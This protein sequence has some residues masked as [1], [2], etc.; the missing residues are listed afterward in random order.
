MCSKLIIC[1]NI[2]P[3]LLME[4]KEEKIIKFMF[5]QVVCWSLLVD[6]G[7]I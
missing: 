6:S 5:L 4:L 2:Y 3:L 7:H 1:V